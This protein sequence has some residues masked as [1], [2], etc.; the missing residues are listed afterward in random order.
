MTNRFALVLGFLF[1][2]LYSPARDKVYF[3]KDSLKYLLRGGDSCVLV[4]A[5]GDSVR[6]PI[7]ED[8]TLVIPASV[9]VEGRT[10]GVEG[11][12]DNGFGYRPEIK[13]VVLSEGILFTREDAFRRC[14]NLES[15]HFPTTFNW[16]DPS[17]FIGCSQLKSI[18]VEEGNE[19]FDSRDNCN[20]LIKTEDKE[21]V[22]GCRY[23]RIPDGITT[24][25]QCA[26]SGQRHMSG[27]NIPEGIRT[28]DNAAFDDCT[29]LKYIT[30]PSTLESIGNAS[31]GG[32][33]SLEELV[34]PANVSTVGE[35]IAVG[36]HNLK[37]IIVSPDNK[38]FD[39]RDSCNAI[40]NTKEDCIVTG[41]RN[42]V[43][44]GNVRMIG[45]GAFSGS[46][47]TRIFLPASVMQIA[48]TAF[49]NCRF[50]TSIEVARDNPVYDS[51]ED[52]NAIIETSTGI[53]VKG[54]AQTTF[55]SG[56]SRIG[57]YA[58]SAMVMPYY[59]V[60]PEGIVSIGHHA[61]SSCNF[62][63]LVLPKSLKEIENSA[64]T[65]CRLLEEVEMNSTDISIGAMAFN[66]CYSLRSVRL[67]HRT[68]FANSEVFRDTPYQDIYEREY[69]KP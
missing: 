36:C 21:L 14:V 62:R 5:V 11:I 19:D 53:L 18:T 46:S 7:T 22:L 60:I 28:I 58:F 20:A 29:G 50:C 9:T 47:L 59:Y 16:T 51:R 52:C 40:V 66:Y 54:C 4:M 26:F 33:T 27:I 8:S 3:I 6:L 34:I 39:S 24:I 2:S 43:I 44:P 32:C 61:F 12:G 25:G 69:G 67:P 65:F 23:T 68:R 35:Y 31:F 37:R 55:P 38:T 63:L 56:V 10:Y 15:V 57:N 64:F 17:S 42:T 48:E 41:C 13:H 1:L 30:L 49:T 45:P